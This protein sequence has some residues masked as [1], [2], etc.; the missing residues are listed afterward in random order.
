MLYHFTP[1]SRATPEAALS[2]LQGWSSRNAGSQ[3][4]L[5][6]PRRTPMLQ[7]ASCCFLQLATISGAVGTLFLKWHYEGRQIQ[8]MTV[9]SLK[10]RMMLEL[11]L[12]WFRTQ[13]KAF[14]IKPNGDI[15][16][17]IKEIFAHND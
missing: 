6:T 16:H 4:L 15:G 10:G 13:A 12:N 1:C 7:D 2:P 8:M 5:D 14:G 9:E 3:Q 11:V 17:V